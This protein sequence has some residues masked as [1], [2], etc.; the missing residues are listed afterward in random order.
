MSNQNISMLKYATSVCAENFVYFIGMSV[1]SIQLHHPA[2]DISLC[3][4]DPLNS[5]TIPGS[6][7]FSWFVDTLRNPQCGS[8]D[9]FANSE[10][11]FGASDVEAALFV[12][13]S[14]FASEDNVKA[15]RHV[16]SLISL[17]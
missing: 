14:F 12:I 16:Q 8:D 6:P 11:Q 17:V 3:F 1:K 13:E 5:L 9:D 15:S 2:R 10:L 7:P 4:P